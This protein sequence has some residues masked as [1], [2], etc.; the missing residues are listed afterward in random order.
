MPVISLGGPKDQ[1]TEEKHKNVT[2][3]D[4]DLTGRKILCQAQDPGGRPFREYPETEE[5]IRNR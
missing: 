1:G 2:S 3:M 5:M 4:W